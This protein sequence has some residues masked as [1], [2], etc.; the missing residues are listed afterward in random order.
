MFSFG[1]LFSQNGLSPEQFMRYYVK[2]VNEEKI[3]EVQN[4][5]H[6]PHSIIENGRIMYYD[7]AEIPVIDYNTFKK[8]GWVYSKINEIKVIAESGNTAI[9]QMDFSRFGKNDKEYLRTTMFYSLTKEK[10]YWQII[11]RTGMLN[12]TF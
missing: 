4:C 10:G 11:N 8:T 1:N 3:K 5:Y 2:V 9:V 7:N 6:F 12:R